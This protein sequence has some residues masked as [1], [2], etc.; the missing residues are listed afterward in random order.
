MI[1]E[2]EEE[3]KQ[4]FTFHGFKNEETLLR[5]KECSSALESLYKGDF[6]ACV[7]EGKSSYYLCAYCAKNCHKGHED[8]KVSKGN[9]KCSCAENG[10]VCPRIVR[11]YSGTEKCV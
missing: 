8:R 6:Y 7:A 11:E 4:T 2:E 5:Y 9:F 10:H 3:E 1:M